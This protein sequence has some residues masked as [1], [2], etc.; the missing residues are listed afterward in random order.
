[1]RRKNGERTSAMLCRVTVQHEWK[2]N[3]KA[4]GCT[5]MA[6]ECNM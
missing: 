2:A 4:L 6:I 1:M 5:A 3:G